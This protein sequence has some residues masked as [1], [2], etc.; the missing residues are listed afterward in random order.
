MAFKLMSCPYCGTDIDD[1]ESEFSVCG[2]CGKRI[3][4]DRANL[5]AFIP[6]GE[7]EDSFKEAVECMVDER[8]AKALAIADE[9][10]EIMPGNPDVLML[11]GAVNAYM[12]EDGKAFNDWK[13]GLGKLENY[14][15]SDAYMCL[16]SKSVADLLYY[17]EVEFIEFDHIR[18]IDSLS[19][20]FD[21]FL[22]TPCKFVLYFTIFLDYIHRIRHDDE[23][24]R[25]DL[26]D[27]LPDMIT[28]LVSYHRNPKCLTDIVD[29]YLKRLGYDNETYEDD[30]MTSWHV[31]YLLSEG[32]K[33]RLSTLTREHLE[34]IR[35]HWNDENM[36]E[37]EEQFNNILKDHGEEG[38]FRLH[39]KKDIEEGDGESV[40]KSVDDYVSKYLLL[41]E[42]RDTPEE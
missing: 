32:I 33:S 11:R 21:G 30:D 9:L 20:E 15:N 22:K 35:D 5:K 34:S 14:T 41:L 25:E 28:R 18:Y 23:V 13:A 8:V 10:L 27:V 16:V 24:D 19:E 26:E 12:G 4:S 3:Y 6:E 1:S 7:Y 37:L 39:K 2:R 38:R 31:Y 29:Y 42:N 36:S 17:K 40:E